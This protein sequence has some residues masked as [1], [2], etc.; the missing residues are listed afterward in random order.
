MKET[1]VS[2]RTVKRMI[3]E[4]K[5]TGRIERIGSNRSGKWAVKD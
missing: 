3:A 2:L 4:L 5:N 1:G